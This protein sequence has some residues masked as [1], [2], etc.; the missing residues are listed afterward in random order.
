MPATKASAR[1]TSKQR[2]T[3]PRSSASGSQLRNRCRIAAILSRKAARMR[4]RRRRRRSL[5]S[6]RRAGCPGRR[7]AAAG[8]QRRSERIAQRIAAPMRR[9]SPPAAGRCRRRCAPS[10]RPPRSASSPAACASWAPARATAG[11]PT[12]PHGGRDAQRT[13]GVGAGAQRQHVA[14][15]RGG[16][17]AGRAAGVEVRIERIA[18]GAPDRIARVGAGA[19]LGHVGLAGD[20]GAGRAQPRHQ[21][22]VGAPAR[23]CGRAASPGG[24]QALRCPPGPSRPAAGRAAGP[25]AA[26]R[27]T[28]RSAARAS[29]RA[30][31][32]QVAVIALTY[33][34][35]ASMRAM[36]ASSS[37]T[38]ESCRAPIRRRSSTA[39][40]RQQVGSA[41]MLS[42][43]GYWPAA[44]WR[45]CAAARCRSRGHRVSGARRPAPGRWRRS[46][47]VRSPGR[48]WSRPGP[49][50]AGLD[51]GGRPRGAKM[52]SQESRVDAGKPLSATVGTSGSC[53]ERGGAGDGNGLD[54]AGLSCGCTRR[55]GVDRQRDLP[56]DQVGHGR[57]TALVRHVDQLDAGHRVPQQ[58]GRE[59]AGRAVAEGAVGVLAG[60]R[61]GRP[62]QLL[63][64]VDRNIAVGEQDQRRARA[65]SPMGSKLLTGS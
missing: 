3:S 8:K 64:I 62:R 59:V 30:R 22:V 42:R 63:Q 28:A 39:G 10:G 48:P 9:P 16:R 33:G 65:T 6:S 18:G 58:L 46:L 44:Q 25:A 31:S 13:A 32:K 29:A 54:L 38:G 34:F 55:N 27:I 36:Q 61:L 19:H 12:T 35:T 17:P 37:S 56:A 14:G 47:L 50:A 45:A 23:G 20:D 7:P 49:S 21:H 40:G 4:R 52:A 1:S 15:Q 26:P 24:Q 11:S 41:A 51:A 57:R 2:C 43:P 5:R 53:A 60:R